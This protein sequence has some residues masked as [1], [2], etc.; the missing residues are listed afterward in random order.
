MTKQKTIIAVFLLVFALMFIPL[1]MATTDNFKPDKV[2]FNHKKLVNGDNEYYNQYVKIKSNSK[3]TIDLTTTTIN[4]GYISI[5]DYDKKDKQS[6]YEV[7][8]YTGNDGVK[9]DIYKSY[10]TDISKKK[11]KDEGFLFAKTTSKDNYVTINTNGFSTLILSIP[12]VEVAF[13]NVQELNLNQY[14]SNADE[15][16]VD[17][18][19]PLNSNQLNIVEGQASLNLQDFEVSIS[20]NGFNEPILSLRN[21]ENIC[22]T[23]SCPYDNEITINVC[24]AGQVNCVSDS[25]D[26]ITPSSSTYY[27]NPRLGLHNDFEEYIDF[28]FNDN[29]VN[30]HKYPRYDQTEF[31]TTATHGSNSGNSYGVSGVDNGAYIFSN[32]FINIDTAGNSPFDF[33]GD[34][35]ISFWVNPN[36]ITGHTVILGNR[37]TNTGQGGFQLQVRSDGS[38][39]YVENDG[40]TFPITRGQ[41]NDIVVGSWQH[42]IFSKS[43]ATGNFYIDGSTPISKSIDDIL[44]TSITSTQQFQIGN[45]LST[46]IDF[47]LDDIA[48]I[49]KAVS[50]S[51]VSYLY[52][53]GFGREFHTLNNPATYTTGWC[54]GSVIGDC[55]F[56]TDDFRGTPNLG[57]TEFYL[58]NY[59]NKQTGED[60]TYNVRYYNHITEGFLDLV[61][62]VAFTSDEFDLLLQD[63]RL[64]LDFKGNIGNPLSFGSQITATNSQGL[65][66][67]IDYTMYF[68]TI[69]T[70]PTELLIPFNALYNTPVIELNM[71]THFQ[72]Y[73]TIEL[74]YYD[75]KF[76]PIIPLQLNTYTKSLSDNTILTEDLGNVSITMETISNSN[77]LINI[78]E[79]NGL[80]Y[81]DTIIIRAYQSANFDILNS[82]TFVE[83]FFTLQ[84]GDL[85]NF[86]QQN[87]SIL[88][89]QDQN[90]LYGGNTLIVLNNHF[91][92]SDHFN[93]TATYDNND[94]TL[95]VPATFNNTDIFTITLTPFA[96]FGFSDYGNFTDNQ[97][98]NTY[99]VNMKIR[100]TNID[101][102][103]AEQ[104]FVI[105]V[106]QSITEEEFFANFDSFKDLFPNLEDNEHVNSKWIGF[107]IILTLVSLAFGFIAHPMNYNTFSLVVVSLVGFLGLFITSW[108]GYT[109]FSWFVTPL[110]VIIAYFVY[111]T[112]MGGGN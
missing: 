2:K 4:K 14:F 71:N 82:S 90:V 99:S 74:E 18:T 62:N 84:S 110:V 76:Y 107:F 63:D 112:F 58:N 48:F 66:D 40:S 47:K 17:Y 88:D 60:Y 92:E 54:F 7:S 79:Q 56:A 100:S 12:D 28:N 105:N 108:I 59:F 75:S 52:N 30:G 106:V 86:N 29:L 93:I 91:I 103:Y 39:S 51:E 97:T 68:Q 96:V 55:L 10:L 44:P 73:D 24:E 36:T 27:L 95:S 78:T 67:T 13:F 6:G 85:T 83:D 42:V 45:E 23:S 57:V 87:L 3:N 9:Y 19:D 16:D 101:G 22:T 94:I 61:N 50:Q 89:I 69:S 26:L 32:D 72:F 38:I 77:I 109:P 8:F 64:T 37:Q 81:D 104:N 49:K 43:G 20:R 111:K 1:S 53:G 98:N 34:F 11:V 65:E 102:F 21:Y 80:T 5:N 25:F 35:S 33:T 15:V 46:N 70:D 31:S 41:T